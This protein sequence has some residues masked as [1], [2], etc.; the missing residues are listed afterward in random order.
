MEQDRRNR[1]LT[2][3]RGNI[4]TNLPE[5]SAQQRVQ[6]FDISSPQAAPP[7]PQ[8][9]PSPKAAPPEGLPATVAQTIEMAVEPVSTKRQ[10]ESREERIRKA[11]KGT[12]VI[13]D[14]I[15]T[16]KN[17]HLTNAMIKQQVVMHGIDFCSR[18][19]RRIS[20]DSR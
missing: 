17:R 8:A 11:A 16:M 1:T 20:D 3:L 4:P 2:D 12:K 10:T 9:A 6:T 13:T 19:P 5:M 14:L 7:T 18:S 15:D